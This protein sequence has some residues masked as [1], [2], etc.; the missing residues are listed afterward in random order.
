MKLIFKVERKEI[1]TS[2]GGFKRVQASGR[3][4]S[5]P[6]LWVVILGFEEA[7]FERLSNWNLDPSITLK[8]SRGP[9]FG[10]RK[11]QKERLSSLLDISPCIIPIKPFV[12]VKWIIRRFELNSNTY[13]YIQLS[14]YP[15]TGSCHIWLYFYFLCFKRLLA[16]NAGLEKQWR[17]CWEGCIWSIKAMKAWERLDWRTQISINGWRWH[18]LC[19][20]ILLQQAGGNSSSS[21]S[22]LVNS[23]CI[24]HQNHSFRAV[25]L[26]S[27]QPTRLKKWREHR[28]KWIMAQTWFNGICRGEIDGP[29]QVFCLKAIGTFILR[30]VTPCN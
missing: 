26:H 20:M 25:Y 12:C 28:C 5:I 9:H 6:F 17:P 27:L 19:T 29:K 2:K 16:T 13:Q 23:N 24:I 3:L 4:E 8:V 14:N 21:S 11:C 30:H 18:N 7:H 22:R 15:I 10:P 1:F